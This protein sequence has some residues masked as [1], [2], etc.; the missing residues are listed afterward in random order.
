MGRDVRR[1]RVFIGIAAWLL[2]LPLAARA[3][4][5]PAPASTSGFEEVTVDLNGQIFNRVLPFDVPFIITGPVPQGISSLEVSCRKFKTDRKS[6]TTEKECW[7]GGKPLTW[8]NTIDP[9]APNPQFRVL[10]P[11]LDR[12][13][14]V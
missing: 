4:D 3:A 14:V 12:K 8:R 10:V 9:A 6:G 5:T 1:S 13:S 2:L 7:A 11:P